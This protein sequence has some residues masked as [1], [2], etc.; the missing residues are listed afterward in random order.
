MTELLRV[1]VDIGGT[2]TDTVLMRGDGTIAA[3]A[4]TLTT[5]VPDRATVETLLTAA[6]GRN[7]F[8]VE[9][10]LLER[11]VKLQPGMEGIG[12]INAELARRDPADLC[13][14]PGGWDT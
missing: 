2:F 9:A 7:F 11:D 12:K 8:R 1:A 3:T 14:G 13:R 5:P 6:D 4:K 10:S